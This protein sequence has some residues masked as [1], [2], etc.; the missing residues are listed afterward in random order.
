MSATHAAAP[1]SILVLGATGKTGRRVLERLQ[2]QGVSVRAG[3][4]TAVP[5]FDWEDR[6]TWAPALAGVSAA[7]V[8]FFPDLAVAGAPETVAAF[9]E[10]AVASGVRRLVLISGRGEI[11]AEQ[12]ERAVQESAI[13]EWTVVRCS[14]FNQNFSESYLL[15]PILDDDLAL[16]VSDVGEPFVDADD[17]ADVAVAALTNDGHAGR[18]YELTGPRLLSF[19]DAAAEIAAAAGRPV[20]FVSASLDDYIAGAAAQGVPDDVLSLLRYVFGEVLDGR[21]A[22]LGDGVQQ[23]LGRAPRDFTDYARDFAATGGWHR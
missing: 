19:A 4:R 17:I 11:G 14:F 15:D 18:V 12:G 3:S 16:P 5:P 13:A 2:G 6:S 22:S 23:A 8:S 9:A 1:E 21:N 10:Q 20:D 7:Y